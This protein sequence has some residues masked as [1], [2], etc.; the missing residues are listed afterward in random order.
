MNSQFIVIV[1]ILLIA[2]VAILI[3]ANTSKK[4]SEPEWK[5]K[6]RSEL[7]RLTQEKSSPHKLVE[8]DKLMDYYL[9]NSKV[10]GETMG[11][12]LKKSRKNFSKQDYDMIWKAHKLRNE[13]VHEVGYKKDLRFLEENIRNL[14]SIISKLS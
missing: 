11:E 13:I 2:F 7:S 5:T 4:P 8:L 1:V 10:K 12:R 3:F 14:T 9:K 6:F